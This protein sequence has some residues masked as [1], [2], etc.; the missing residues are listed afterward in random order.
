MI[1]AYCW[2]QSGQPKETIT[3][4]CHTTA[5]SFQ[6]E[7][8]RQGAEDKTVLVHHHMP[9][10]IQ[11]IKDDIAENG[12][13]WQPA[14]ELSIDT[15]WPS[16]FY[17]ILLEDSD[18]NKADAFFVV[19]PSTATDAMFVL[20][21]STWNAYNTWGGLSYYT[22]GHIVSPMRPLQ[23][24]FLAKADPHRHR[25]ARFKDWNRED[26][27][28]FVAAGYDE[29]SMAAGWANWE[30]LFA[31]WA[32]SQGYNIGYAVSYDL[33]QHP[34]LLDGYPAYISVGHDEYWSAGM[35]DTVENYIDT[36]GNAAFFSGNTSF[37]QVRFDEGY[38]QMTGYKCDMQ[39]DPV[40]NPDH[41]PGQTPTLATMWSDPLIG[42]PECQMTGVSFSRG[43]YAHMPNSPEGTG[44]Y[45]VWQPEHWSFNKTGLKAGD[46]LGADGL[47][48]G[49]ECDGC[50]LAFIDNQM[51][52]KFTDG[53]P[54]GFEILATAQA[55]LWETEE[56]LG[57]LADNYIGE[58]N[59][60]AARIG[61]A[62][63]PEM[64]EKFANGHAVMGS[65]KRG[66]GEVFTTGCTDWAYGLNDSAVAQVTNNVL[67]RFIKNL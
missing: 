34:N 6:I 12:C 16:G 65:F 21:T 3:L 25:I 39:D 38:H 31:R 33:D 2:P 27:R 28:A 62:D 18:G 48:L 15:N 35:R 8:I 43:G 58:L 50:E 19:R 63:T 66:K 46:S 5:S 26:A 51:V 49:Y 47:V 55:H 14:I 57:G 4:Y 61:G 52:P 23:P 22:G 42:R 24:G 9:G 17:L 10:I 41:G 64:R 60:V 32:E 44:G 40:F 45:T 13:Q 7:V 20:S 29:W 37:W 1:A 54:E 11:P 30:I 36:G 59:W 56:A 53:T 67:E